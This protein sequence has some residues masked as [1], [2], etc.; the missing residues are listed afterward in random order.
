MVP[1]SVHGG[2]EEPQVPVRSEGRGDGRGRL[3]EGWRYRRARKN[4]CKNKNKKCHN[5]S[6]GIS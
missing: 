5:R 4:F 1:D 3:P 6:C 2:A